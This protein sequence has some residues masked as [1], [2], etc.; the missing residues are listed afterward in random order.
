MRTLSPTLLAAQKSASGVPYVKAVLHD[1]IG[2][3]RWLTWTRLYIGAEPDG[4][5]AATMPAD[6]SLIGRG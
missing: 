6:G 5:H 3:I 1:R 2:G 4:Y